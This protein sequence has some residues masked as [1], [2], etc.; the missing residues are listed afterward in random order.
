MV[1]LPPLSTRLAWVARGHQAMWFEL[2]PTG[3]DGFEPVRPQSPTQS[4]LW[5]KACVC[6]RAGYCQGVKGV[7]T[8]QSKKEKRSARQRLLRHWPCLWCALNNCAGASL[9]SSLRKEA[10]TW[11]TGMVTAAA[12]K[13]LLSLYRDPAKH[14]LREI[15][16]QHNE[17]GK[18]D[19]T[20]A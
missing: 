3:S 11:A 1:T 13:A 14:V 5:P 8:K 9:A 7:I 4:P 15:R 17:K 19:F 12:A 18:S 20:V 2:S 10:T 6:E 16:F